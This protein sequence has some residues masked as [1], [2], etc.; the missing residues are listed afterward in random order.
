M[1]NNTAL[2]LL[3]AAALLLPLSARAGASKPPNGSGCGGVKASVCA[4]AAKAA[5][6]AAVG[7]AD[8]YARQLSG[9][10]LEI[11]PLLVVFPYGDE[12]DAVATKDGSIEDVKAL[13][14]KKTGYWT[15]VCD[16][17]KA[18]KKRVDAEMAQLRPD[19]VEMLAELSKQ[20]VK[21]GRQIRAVDKISGD[22]AEDA[23][24]VDGLP[25]SAKTDAS[26]QAI[27]TRKGEV[28]KILQSLK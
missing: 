2:K 20:S 8:G 14:K 18:E 17:L 25:D 4:A 5:I 13:L 22:I 10:P 26:R 6:A 19:D 9:V 21:L 16:S 11:A 23:K 1:T 12:G 27:I 3:T 28:L 24:L 7:K 15:A